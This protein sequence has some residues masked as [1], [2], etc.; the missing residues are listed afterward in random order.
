MS[1]KIIYGWW[2]PTDES[3]AGRFVIPEQEGVGEDHDLVGSWDDKPTEIAKRLG[4][5]IV[6]Y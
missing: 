1:S 5:V 3:N 6:E 2:E 4:F